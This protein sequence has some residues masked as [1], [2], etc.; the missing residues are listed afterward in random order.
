M[1]EFVKI[2]MSNH[3]NSYNCNKVLSKSLEEVKRVDF[4]PWVICSKVRSEW[5]SET[6]CWKTEGCTYLK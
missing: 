2:H 5:G 1:V 6:H 3:Q 4:K